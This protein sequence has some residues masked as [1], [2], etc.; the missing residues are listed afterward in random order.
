MKSRL[1]AGGLGTDGWAGDPATPWGRGESPEA[2]P[3]A[4]PCTV[5]KV[6]SKLVGWLQCRRFVGKEDPGAARSPR[7]AGALQSPCCVPEGHSAPHRSVGAQKRLLNKRTKARKGREVRREGGRGAHRGARNDQSRPPGGS[8][9]GR[10]AAGTTG[11]SPAL[12]SRGAGPAGEASEPDTRLAVPGE[13]KSNTRQERA[14][15]CVL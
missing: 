1:F 15:L 2:C 4:Q 12:G 3:G 8:T 7:G 13:K 11:N 6:V 5:P 14:A 10:A 9:E